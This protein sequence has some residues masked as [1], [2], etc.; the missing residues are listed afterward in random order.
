MADFRLLF[1]IA[2]AAALRFRCLHLFI[3]ISYF[4]YA[5][6][7]DAAAIRHTLS[8]LPPFRLLSFS[9]FISLILLFGF[10]FR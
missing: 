2:I 5:I 10:L 3:F 8:M 4:A 9:L 6:S 7:P 1:S